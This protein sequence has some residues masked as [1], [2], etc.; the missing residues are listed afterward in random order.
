MTAEAALGCTME[1][2]GTFLRRSESRG[3]IQ[4]DCWLV[5][6]AVQSLGYCWFFDLYIRQP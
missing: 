6:K 4:L 2:S 3:G 1:D 5:L